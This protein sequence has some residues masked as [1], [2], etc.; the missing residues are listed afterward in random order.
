M[1]NWL[2]KQPQEPAKPSGPSYSPDAPS[3]YALKGKTPVATGPVGPAQEP[4]PVQQP[5]AG[6]FSFVKPWWPQKQYWQNY[7][8]GYWENPQRIARYQAIKETQPFDSEI[9]RQ[10]AMP[11]WYNAKVMG[12]AYKKLSEQNAGKPW[13]L[14]NYLPYDDPTSLELLNLPQPPKDP[15]AG[16]REYYPGGRVPLSDIRRGWQQ[17]YSTIPEEDI[18]NPALGGLTNKQYEELPTWMK[19]MQ[20]LMTA[21]GGIVQPT[22]MGAVMGTFGA[23]GVGTLIGGAMGAGLGGVGLLAQ[24]YPEAPGMPLVSNILKWLNVPAEHM[25]RALGTGEMLWN[26]WRYPEEGRDLET[27]L[28]NLPQ[29]YEANLAYYESGQS[30]GIPDV[31]YHLEDTYSWLKEKEDSGDLEWKD[32]IP[33]LARMFRGMATSRGGGSGIWNLASVAEAMKKGKIE[34]PEQIF[35]YIAGPG[36]EWYLGAAAPMEAPIT[37]DDL[38][39]SVFNE[40]V[41]NPDA[42]VREIME[43]AMYVDGMLNLNA[44]TS[45]LVG[46]VALDPLNVAGPI[47]KAPIKAYAGLTKNKYLQM[48]ARVQGGV[49]KVFQ[50][51]GAILR[52]AVPAEEIATMGSVA[53]WLGDVTKDGVPRSVNYKPSNN[54]AIRAVSWLFQL[55][56]KARAGETLNHGA[57]VLMKVYDTAKNEDELLGLVDKI[58]NTPDELATELSMKAIQSPDARVIPMAS[59]DFMPTA[60]EM[61][62]N[63]KAYDWNRGIFHAVRDM[64]KDSTSGLLQKIKEVKEFDAV[65]ETIKR[66]AYETDTDA[67]KLII[68]SIEDG[69]L[70]A[71]NLRQK[72]LP[73]TNDNTFVDFDHLKKAMV[74]AQMEHMS[75]WAATW[76]GVKPDPLWVRLSNTMKASQ[77][78]LLLGLNPTYFF[79]NTIDNTVVS[80]AEGIFGFNTPA[81]RAKIWDEMLGKGMRPV[82]YSDGQGPYA[83][84]INVDYTGLT[85]ATKKTD[86]LNKVNRILRSKGVEK[87]QVFQTLSSNAEAHASAQGYT[88]ATKQFYDTNW[89]RGLGFDRMPA[90][91]ENDLRALNPDLPELI[92][93]IIEGGISQKAIE[94]RLWANIKRRGLS[95]AVDDMVKESQAAGIP[96]DINQ[97]TD[98][99]S[100][101]GVKEF[102]DER[103]VDA[104]TPEQVMDVFNSLDEHIVKK[105]D[106]M[107]TRETKAMTEQAAL[108][109]SAQG[110]GLVGVLPIW[111]KLQEQ[112]TQRWLAGYEHWEAAFL[113]GEK[114]DFDARSALYQ[115]TRAQETAHWNRYY[116][117]EKAHYLGI[118]QGLGVCG[119]DT[120]EL[121][122]F[123]EEKMLNNKEFYYAK[124]KALDEFWG[125]QWKSKVERDAGWSSTVDT[126][127]ELS[128]IRMDQEM[129]LMEAMDNHLAELAYNQFGDIGKQAVTEWR[130]GVRNIVKEMNLEMDKFQE[131]LKTIKGKKRHDAW[132]NFLQTGGG[133]Y[134][135]ILSKY[136]RNV[137]GVREMIRKIMGVGEEKAPPT[138]PGPGPEPSAPPTHAAPEG[139]PKPME[140]AVPG[141]VTPVGM[142][143]PAEKAA[144]GAEIP[145]APPPPEPKIIGSAADAI[146]AMRQQELIDLRNRKASEVAQK[147]LGEAV[148]SQD[149]EQLG[150][151]LDDIEQIHEALGGRTSEELN[152][153]WR[154]AY[155]EYQRVQRG[156]VRKVAQEYGIETADTAGHYKRGADGRIYQTVKKYGPILDDPNLAKQAD[157]VY[158]FND[159]TEELA[160]AVFEKRKEMK[161]SGVDVQYWQIQPPKEQDLEWY[162]WQNDTVEQLPKAME[163]RDI[164]IIAEGAGDVFRELTKTYPDW[165][166]IEEKLQ[167]IEREVSAVTKALTPE[168]TEQLTNYVNEWLFTADMPEH[169]EVARE[170]N[171][172]L[173]DTP[174]EILAAVAKVRDLKKEMMLGRKLHPVEHQI[175]DA[176]VPISEIGDEVVRAALEERLG[177]MLAE[178]EMGQPAQDI[179]I[180]GRYESTLPKTY[181][182]WYETFK[183]T[184]YNNPNNDIPA[185]RRKKYAIVG[186]LQDMIKGE[187]VDVAITRSLREIALGDIGNRSDVRASLGLDFSENLFRRELNDVEKTLRDPRIITIEGQLEKVEARLTDLELTMPKDASQ[188]LIDDYLAIQ[189][190]LADLKYPAEPTIPEMDDI[191]KTIPYAK[192]IQEYIR[193]ATNLDDAARSTAKDDTLPEILYQVGDEASMRWFGESAVSESNG[194]PLVVYHGTDAEQPFTIFA[195]SSDI[196]FHFGTAKA[197]NDR[198]QMFG[199]L[200]TAPPENSRILPVILKIVNPMEVSDAFDPY[201]LI[202]DMEKRNYISFRE[203]MKLINEIDKVKGETYGEFIS[204]YVEGEKWTDAEYFA[205]E[206]QFKDSQQLQWRVLRNYIEDLGYDGLKYINAVEGVVDE[207][208]NVTNDYSWVAFRANQIKS[209]WHDGNYTDGP[210]ILFQPAEQ[211]SMFPEER[212]KLTLEMQEAKGGKFKPG[213]EPQPILPGMEDA[214]QSQLRMKGA[215][216]AG[217]GEVGGP[218]FG[219]QNMA[220]AA[221][222]MNK[223]QVHMDLMHYFELWPEEAQVVIDVIDR[224]ANLWAKKYG[225][226]PEEYYATHFA[227]IT[228]EKPSRSS[229]FQMLPDSA[230]LKGSARPE[231]TITPPQTLAEFVSQ[232]QNTGTRVTPEQAKYVGALVEAVAETAGIDPDHFVSINWGGVKRSQYD[233][234]ATGMIYKTAL[235]DID[236]MA[237]TEYLNKVH[238]QDS[239][240]YFDDFVNFIMRKNRSFEIKDPDTGLPIIDPVTGKKMKGFNAVH[241]NDKTLM[242]LDVSANCPFRKMNRSCIICYVDLPRSKK[243][244]GIQKGP[245]N[246]NLI[247]ESAP[248]ESMQILDMPQDTVDFLN[249]SGGMRV[250]SIGDFQEMDIPV[251]D[252]AVA[253]AAER[254][255]NLK[256]ITKQPEALERYG[257]Y[258]HVYFNL[259]TDYNPQHADAL[260][261]FALTQLIEQNRQL[262]KAGGHS[263]KEIDAMMPRLDVIKSM[264]ADELPEMA[265]FVMRQQSMLVESLT[266]ANREISFG[267][268]IDEAA[269]LAKDNPRVAVRYVA[270]NAEDAVKAIMDDRF[271]VVTLYHGNVDPDIF[272]IVWDYQDPHLKEVLGPNTVD[273]LAN[274]YSS[275]KVPEF[276][277]AID[278]DFLHKWAGP[279]ATMDEFTD[280]A[281][282]KLCCGTGR[283]STCGVCCGFKRGDG[284]DIINMVLNGVNRSA[285]EFG[286]DGKAIMHAFSDATNVGDFANSLMPVFVKY[287]TPDDSSI[288]KAEAGLKAGA[289]WNEAALNKVGTWFEIYLKKRKNY[290]TSGTYRLPIPERLQPMFDKFN[291]WLSRIYWKVKSN[292]AYKA[293][294]NDT[295]KGIFDRMIGLTDKDSNVLYKMS[296]DQMMGETAR[297]A[298]SFLDDGKAIIHALNNPDLTTVLHEVGH[299]FRRDL[300]AADLKIAEDWAGAKNGV[301]TRAAE[302]KFADGWVQYLREGKAPVEGLARVFEQLKEW[303]ATIYARAKGQLPNLTDEMRGVYDRLLAEY[304]EIEE[305][306]IRTEQGYAR[307]QPPDAR[308]ENFMKWF[309]ESK[310]M[311]EDGAPK[312]VYHGTSKMN[313]DGAD[314]DIFDPRQGVRGWMYFTDDP[315]YASEMAGEW[316]NARIKPVNLKMENPLDLSNLKHS[317]DSSVD[318]I[319]DLAKAIGSIPEFAAEG[320]TEEFIYNKITK[321][322]TDQGRAAPAIPWVL[323][324]VLNDSTDLTRIARSNGYDGF[325]FPDYIDVWRNGRAA[326]RV[327]AISYVVFDSK[328]VKSIYN[329]GLYDPENPSIL[330]QMED[331]R[332]LNLPQIEDNPAMNL[333]PGSVGDIDDNAPQSWMALDGY[334]TIL[335]PLLDGARER[336][337]SDDAVIPE[338]IQNVGQAIPEETMRDLRGYMGNVYG[339][340]N[341]TKLA[342]TRYGEMKR[343]SALLN[344]NKRYNFDNLL[345]AIMPYQFWYTRSAAKWA[346]RAMDSPAIFANYARLRSAQTK[347]L[348][349]PGFPKRLENKIRMPTPFLPEWMGGGLY[350]DPLK[351]LFPFTQL[352]RPYD[353]YAEEQ[354]LI[355]KRAQG[356]IENQVENGEITPEEAKLALTNLE[357]PVWEQAYS[358]AYL[359]VEPEITS[360]IE[361]SRV[362]LGWSLPLT[363][364]YEVY[365]GRPERISQ[366][367]I[368]RTIQNITG[369]LGGMLGGS[370]KGINI[371]APLRK[372]LGLPEQDMWQDYRIER[373][374]SNMAAEGW[375]TEEILRAQ[376]EYSGPAFEEAERRVAATGQLRWIGGP[377]GVDLFPEG[378]QK[379]RALKNDYDKA[380]EAWVNGGKYEDTVGKFFDEYPEYQARKQSFIDDPEERLRMLMR[381]KIWDAYNNK[382]SSLQK[383]EVTERLGDVFQ[384]AFLDKETRSYDSI[385]TATLALWSKTMGEYVPTSAP[386]LPQVEFEFSPPEIDT[387]YQAYVDERNTRFPHLSRM[388][389]MLYSL[390]ENQRQKISDEMPMFD[391]YYDWQ[392]VYLSEHPDIIEYVL[393]DQAKMKGAPAEAQA[394][395]YQYYGQVETLWG[396]E[397]YDIQNGY[398][399]QPTRNAKRQ[400]LKE[401][402]QL[403]DFWDHKDSFLSMYPE[404]IPYLKSVESIAE[405]VLGN[406][407]EK[408]VQV[409]IDEMPTSLVR[410]LMGYYWTGDPLSDGARIAVR[411][412]WEDMGRPGG[413]LDTFIDEILVTQF[414]QYSPIQ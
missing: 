402:P 211:L 229:L 43:R 290:V 68:K 360:P 363:W 382:L 409:N 3:Y 262:L 38:V 55:Q 146:S 381:S 244:V 168:A 411:K 161:E 106:E 115:K 370:N 167:R 401:F 242:A 157:D 342:A 103:L 58:S 100:K 98:L 343:D 179:Y 412:I 207:F 264:P 135:K 215:V 122:R 118:A 49:P 254:G 246:P 312:T 323:M 240:K 278:E 42:N 206:R 273:I 327:D 341:D 119:P 152:D 286:H 104:V 210:S 17:P 364:A 14:W 76:F 345:Q 36:E 352:T 8:R 130:E 326:D 67:A 376:V 398:Y 188:D 276:F 101:L 271:D 377:F 354:N 335:K 405:D 319:R 186:A 218:L 7:V 28:A 314:F 96:L 123:V 272:K 24:K 268:D 204:K 338:G 289:E 160:R 227:E 1:L 116:M 380:M 347:A 226:T 346:L 280:K 151:A 365:K 11:P 407:Y 51:Y 296:Y 87:I 308:A 25:E 41:S 20:G 180:E 309:G 247:Y 256:M 148:V 282:S 237:V 149:W 102:L 209:I 293:T 184:Y 219:E 333:P 234:T 353:A 78:F 332:E 121:L 83:T 362:L 217:S 351:K 331:G 236:N 336:I 344:Y 66:A 277:K 329:G 373:E 162:N 292:T 311:D 124:Q 86:F 114:L 379:Q 107:I 13:W 225:K 12:D 137:V 99:I 340:Q 45:D 399:E 175:L 355:N 23:P 31:M 39:W 69:T 60:T 253:D 84:G 77:S 224:R 195:R 95:W 414:M 59:K 143:G 110:E 63:F 297:G 150:A 111:D 40:L 222:G 10:A 303:I 230:Y 74:G 265:K 79:N 216:N 321:L 33:G 366:L 233:S 178:I 192:E 30:A 57:D 361:F 200:D 283:C 93:G 5:S 19:T 374:L 223:M 249:A 80:I 393:S 387:Q 239:D 325:I 232:I 259:S 324:K 359:D 372:Q 71:D 44:I 16:I 165:G 375:D 147:K 90:I 408:K 176:T 163:N 284:G 65:F 46:Q 250:F 53:R 315:R 154:M 134:E 81:S 189:A 279:D 177:E 158:T 136:E 92:Y 35:D 270:M 128:R 127:N 27:I 89:R 263:P 252:Q 410:S 185:T 22:L 61:V 141:E 305:Y 191:M 378:E 159:I 208:G 193:R 337:A 304:P 145:E 248:Y 349:Q 56:P 388:W 330:F 91:L 138:E 258:E 235:P 301:W 386:E 357:G 310:I 238:G 269:A 139:G 32:A 190:R 26:A 285:V 131:R 172:S 34:H 82:R 356:I 52:R 369:M 266:T 125:T 291:E 328:Q 403:I 221:L 307:I 133:Y 339:Q 267:W 117:I 295:V 108:A 383:K 174:E 54:A 198:L 367:P 313:Y 37:G 62:D 18:Q 105:L 113:A 120:L 155:E 203:S 6:G 94:N 50:T 153:I 406:N 197:A 274:M 400:Y 350:M 275:R 306:K 29:A 391:D 64:L 199:L 316:N 255:L 181:P 281:W 187:A 358:K 294:V 140:P 261:E 394:L 299:I 202:E 183:Q 413:D 260:S 384:N 389:D 70:Y 47:T 318:A 142:E 182:V 392:T 322:Y 404:M 298:V 390:P 109:T 300:D 4:E 88:I 288:L 368:S 129:Q 334:E 287:L 205:W 75:K 132:R 48:A 243:A 97:A 220:A 251:L 15:W 241:L 72:L 257:Q 126:I 196:G 302:E 348:Q 385:D 213:E 194:M 170:L 73:F 228:N 212:P 112:Y 164:G 166:Y 320:L 201:K 169:L 173:I 144:L 396:D 9:Q 397:I 371:E 231:Q 395:Y 21:G 317:Y 214:M 245:V 171:L 2:K 85:E 156:K